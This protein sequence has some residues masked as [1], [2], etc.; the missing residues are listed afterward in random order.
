MLGLISALQQVL[1][2]EAR[3]HVYVG[4]TVQDITDTWFALVMRDVGA[5]V[6]RDLRAIEDT[7]LDAGRRASR[8][9][10]GRTN[11][12]STRLSDHVRLQGCVM[13]RRGSTPSSAAL[14]GTSPM[15]GR[16]ARWSRGHPGVLR[17]ARCRAAR[18]VLCRAGAGRP[19]HL[20]AH[21]AGPDRG[22]RR[23][24]GDDLRHP[25]PDRQ[26]GL[27]AAAAGDRR[28]ARADHEPTRSAASRCR[29]SAIPR[30]ASTWTRWRDWSGPTP[31]VLTEG[32]VVGHERDGR[33]WKA[34]WVALPEVCLLTGVALELA[35]PAAVRPGRRRE[36]MRT[37][38]DTVTAT[39]WRPSGCSPG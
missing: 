14:G 11:A 20:V 2:E 16:P 12:R 25:G 38:L 34:E 39:S 1:P 26:R 33:G 29:T 3:E 5:V 32:M 9:A 13:G 18:R 7:L 15:A 24:A 28:A 10:H 23:T 17:T 19:G 8:H 21:L 35:L 30:A 22:V 6:W 4:A 31:Q 37:N 27:R 36:T